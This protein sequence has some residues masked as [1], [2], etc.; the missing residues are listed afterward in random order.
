M[1][2]QEELQQK[3][4]TVRLAFISRYLPVKY[5]G[6]GIHDLDFLN[7]LSTAGIHVYFILLDDEN[8]TDIFK[9]IPDKLTDVNF[10]YAHRHLQFNSRLVRIPSFK[11]LMRI[12]LLLLIYLPRTIARRM[13]DKYKQLYKRI[14]KRDQQHASAYTSEKPFQRPL[15]HSELQRVIPYIQQQQCNVVVANYT[16]LSNIF[17]HIHDTDI[18]KVI[19]TREVLRERY[20]SFQK[21]NLCFD[22]TKEMVERELTDLQRG[23]VLLAIQQEDARQLRE[24]SPAAEVILAPMAETVKHSAVPQVPARCL[25]AG[26]CTEHNIAGLDWFFAEIWERVLALSPVCHLYVYGSICAH[27]AGRAIPHVTFRGI[28]DDLDGEYG[29]AQLC[30]APLV[31]GSGLKVKV[32][33][34]MS[35]CRAM[36]TTAV[37]AQ[38]IE[39]AIDSALAV[40]NDPVE[41]ANLLE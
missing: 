29:A 15:Q 39:S 12:F 13:P 36:L 1:Q 7:Y 11:E 18:C 4:E 41:Y 14:M 26:S 28:V 33:E 35:H 27:Y 25:F 10:F 37:G 2:V 34:A 22:G 23:D 16:F 3:D 32:V 40:A 24:M 17:D 9:R 21:A 31:A 8:F 38:G 5:F 19:I 30:L 6:S 20:E